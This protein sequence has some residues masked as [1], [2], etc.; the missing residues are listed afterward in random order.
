MRES[1]FFYSGILCRRAWKRELATGHLAFTGTLQIHL[2]R[3]SRASERFS[4]FLA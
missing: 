4:V 2:D 3:P 1:R